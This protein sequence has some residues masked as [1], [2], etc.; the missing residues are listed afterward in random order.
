MATV[1][2]AKLL[3]MFD[4]IGSLTPGKKADLIILNP[5]HVNFAPRFEWVN[6]IVFNGSPANVE[7]VFIDGHPLKRKGELVGVDPETVVGAAQKA[8]TRIRRDLLN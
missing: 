1:D 3:N 8:A 5:R 2:G 4:R 7:W 6:Q